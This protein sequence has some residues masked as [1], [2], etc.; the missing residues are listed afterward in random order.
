[1]ICCLLSCPLPPRLALYATISLP[2]ALQPLKQQSSQGQTRR[3]PAASL[4]TAIHHS[5][6]YIYHHLTNRNEEGTTFST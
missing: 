2:A 1:N 3:R 5:V 6:L 4:S